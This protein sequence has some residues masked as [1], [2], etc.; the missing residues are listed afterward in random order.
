MYD[1]KRS[2]KVISPLSNGLYSIQQNGFSSGLGELSH[3]DDSSFNHYCLQQ[4]MYR[5]I[6]KTRYGIDVAQMFLVIFHKEYDR[7]YL[8]PVPRMDKE[9]NVIL[10]ELER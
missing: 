4:N 9:I 10:S 8:L 3:L 2:L 6:L 7:Y 5:R 1:W